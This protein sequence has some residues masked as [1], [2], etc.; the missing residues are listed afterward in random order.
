MKIED[1]LNMAA[2]LAAKGDP[3]K[4]YLLGCIGVRTD[5]AIVKSDNLLIKEPLPEAHAEF[6]VVRKVD[7]G[8]CLYVAR[9]VR[10]GFLWANS[11][12][13]P[14]CTARIKNKKIKAVYYTIGPS[15]YGV[16]YP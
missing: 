4:N 5:G 3:A 12:P 6:R 14:T 7:K 13:C 16:W 8:S 1:Y 10:K 15:E 2:E 11:R 9:V